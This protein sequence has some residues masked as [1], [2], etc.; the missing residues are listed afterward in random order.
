[1]SKERLPLKGQHLE[2]G[3]HQ[4]AQLTFC[5]QCSLLGGFGWAFGGKI[6]GGLP[7]LNKAAARVRAWTFA[8]ASKNA[9]AV[10]WV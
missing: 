4:R 6:S 1:M 7:P 2:F 9:P 3:F 5:P 8:H 10:N